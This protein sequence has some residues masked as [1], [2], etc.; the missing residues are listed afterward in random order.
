[1]YTTRISFLKFWGSGIF[2]L[3]LI[4]QFFISCGTSDYNYLVYVGTYTDKGS[5]GIYS[6]KF[7]PVTSNVDS[8]KLSAET[9]NPSFVA[10][11]PKGQFLY[12]VNELDTFDNEQTGA[13]SVFNINR[14]S[15]KLNLI[16]QVSSLGAAPA[17]LS[18]DK[19]GKF[20]LVANYTGGNIAVFPI[21]LDGK[22]G[23]HSAFIQNIGF[24]VNEERQTSPH[25]HYINVTN[26]NNYVMV[27][28]LGI[29]K[30]LIFQFDFTN[31]SL[32]PNNPSCINLEPGSG[33]R[34]FVFSHSGKF[35]YVLNEL[36]STVTIFDFDP[37]DTTRQSKQT[38]STLP[39]NFTGINT[40]AEILID[41]KGKFLYASNR[42]DDSIVQFCIDTVTG[43]L[44]P[45]A[46][47]SSGGKTPRNFEIDPSGKWM[48]SANQN[49]DNIILFK[50]DQE[51]GRLTNT[52]QTI[53][54]KSP[55][56]IR[57]LKINQNK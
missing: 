32:K 43:M 2:F 1:M 31:G 42:G 48:F 40:T 18:L 34:H 30:I 11:D 7:N 22:L 47:V 33:P 35:I 23:K 36:K 50:I 53:N 29:D 39:Q 44:S 6:F 17:H 4:F 41:S 21:G 38:I 45:I 55:V 19:S 13:I 9:V 52:K 3:F 26:D 24:S 27:A 8:I 25:A 5:E 14:E 57:F 54:I 28:D 46:W 51:N 15:G 16:Q 10:I 56:C 37:T 12:A 20:L 49:S